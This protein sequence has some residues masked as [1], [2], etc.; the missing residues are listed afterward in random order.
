MMDELKL[1][2][3][4]ESMG[5]DDQAQQRMLA[6]IMAAH[7]ASENTAE[8]VQQRS[9]RRRQ[10]KRFSLV[11]YAIPIA[12]CLVLA[13]LSPLTLPQL[14]S[15]VGSASTATQATSQA[16][17]TPQ[18][19]QTGSTAGA[20]ADSP[21]PGGTADEAADTALEA[22][23]PPIQEE[24]LEANVTAKTSPVEI[25]VFLAPLLLC[26]AALVIA[27]VGVFAWRRFKRSSRLKPPPPVERD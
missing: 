3:A 8:Q 20:T 7:E 21:A 9:K 18:S 19:P 1:R 22:T 27:F 13:V 11:R 16:S 14:V 12:A 15:S 23:P 5:P 6:N 26:L 17:K 4:F 10:P 2:G 24:P 25:M